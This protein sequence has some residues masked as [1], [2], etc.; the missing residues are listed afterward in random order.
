MKS[1][2]LNLLMSIVLVT[3]IGI[4]LDAFMFESNAFT[5]AIGVRTV[6]LPILIGMY[7]I[8]AILAFVLTKVM[9]R[10]KD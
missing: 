5:T 4:M 8:G 1:F 10:K 3:I 7:G 9:N 2:S 6:D